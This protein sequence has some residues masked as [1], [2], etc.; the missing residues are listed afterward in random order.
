MIR[1]PNYRRATNAAYEILTHRA[2][3]SLA[4]NVFAI[5]EDFLDTCKLLTY[6]QACFFYDYTMEM[7]LE[8]SEFGFSIVSGDRRV[9]LYNE[10]MPLGS[11]RFTIAHEIGHFILNHR[12]EHDSAAEKEANCFARNLLCPIPVVY[13]L[14]VESA[15]DY[16][17]LFNITPRMSTVAFA[18]QYD[19][20]ENISSQNWGLVSKKL[21]AYM[22]GAVDFSD[23]QSFRVS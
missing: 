7:L 6:S 22:L 16:V 23:S 17:E 11:I 2:S 10:A 14:T 13:E 12:D 5:V 19:D 4:T 18:K 8:V 21:E 3:F 20:K 1:Y 15:L 9:I